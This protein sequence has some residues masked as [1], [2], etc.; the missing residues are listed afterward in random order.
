M[1]NKGITLIEMV[2]VIVVLGTSIPFLMTMWSDTTW[3]SARSEALVDGSF[4]AQQLM[5]EIKTKRFDENSASPW[6]GSLGPDTSTV[7]LN[8]TANE[9]AIGRDNWDDVDDFNGY[10]GSPAAGYNFCVT[11]DYISLSGTTWSGTCSPNSPTTCTKPTC[12]SANR[13]DYKR[14]IVRVW[15]TDNVLS[16]ISL[17]T[18]VSGY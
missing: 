8:G 14:I 6:S 9:T 13:T 15:R 2:A 3:R 5:E 1:N 16:D 11:V 4:Y 17:V 7:G 18:M 10:T 12:T